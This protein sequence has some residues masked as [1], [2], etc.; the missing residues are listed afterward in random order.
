M[1]IRILAL[2]LAAAPALAQGA[3]E[4]AQRFLA[5]EE[6]AFQHYRRQDYAKAVAAFERQIAI[7]PENPRPY[8]NIACCYGLEGD[9]ERAATWL[10]L[11][12]A[13][14][15]RDADHLAQDPDFDRVRQSAGYIACLAQLKRARQ[16]D[17]DPLPKL[18]PPASVPPAPSLRG[19]VLASQVEEEQVRRMNRLYEP[20]EYRKRLFEIYDRRMAVLAR[21]MIENGDALDAGEAAAARVQTALFY[22]AEAEGQG[23]PDRMLR[24]VAGAYVLQTVEEFLRGWPG[25]AR[26]PGALLAR[27]V[28]LA[29]LR[30][31]AEAVPLLRTIRAD[32]A[33]VAARAEV[34][35]AALLGPGDELKEVFRS[36][37]ARAAGDED[38]ALLMRA[39]LMAARLHVEGMPNLLDLDRT[40]AV[41]ARV[42]AHEGPVAYVFVACESQA[43]ERR[44]REM[45]AAGGR[46]LTVVVC[47]DSAERVNELDLERWL[48]EH[49]RGQPSIARG[50]DAVERIW[51]RDLPT[52]IVA[53]K[54]GTVVAIDPDA[55][56]LAK[57]AGS[58]G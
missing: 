12:I 17:P 9:G 46:L 20:H 24:E 7:Y 1:R 2:L 40:G 57:L 5:Q 18:V 11:S 56:E 39:R 32:H 54:D 52:V 30:R 34:E 50:A 44:L 33:A 16:E 38:L 22:L 48:G 28:A 14:G 3:Q 35:L 36:L 45:P 55:G 21:Y 58:R 42:E 23:E 51:L 15:W 43:C 6:E 13:R 4:V 8:Y 31:D 49:A 41:A 53:R 29:A 25:D 10:S 27:A 47:V 19:A 26:L 37:Q